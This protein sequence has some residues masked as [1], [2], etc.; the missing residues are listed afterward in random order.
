MAMKKNIH[1]IVVGAGL[2][3][4]ATAHG[5]VKNGISCSI[6]DRETAP[7]DRNWGV[8]LS[9]AHPL[10]RQ[11]LP[12]ALYSTLSR[13]QPDPSLD[14]KAAG[15]EC[16]LVRDGATG[17]TMVEPR[18]PGVRRL[19]IRKTKTAWREGLD[20]RYGKKLVGIDVVKDGV[21]ATFE[22]GTS[23]KGDVIVGADGGASYVRRWLLGE[24]A[25]QE[26]LPYT[27][28]NF[29]FSVK[30]DQARWLESV[31][32]PNV[33]V[34][35]HPKSMY[36][37]L[38]L[39]DKPDLER[40]ETWIFYLLVT[41]PTE[42]GDTD[43][44]I[45]AK[46]SK[47]RLQRLKGK[48]DGWADPY[49]SAVEWLPDDVTIKPDQLRIWHPKSWNSHGGRVTLSGDAAHSM[50][51]HRGQGGNLAIKDALEFVNAMKSVEAGKR[52]LEDAI[53]EYDAGVLK[54]GE[55]VEISKEQAIA[56]HNYATFRDSP[57]FKMGLKPNVK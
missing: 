47:R 28:M 29:P 38:F 44:D 30:T 11:L 56:F 36:I 23:E 21:V 46:G 45:T 27:F 13:C 35:T 39:L 41:W 43:D 12:D 5:L 32:N 24:A 37:G 15:K 20:I 9:W 31:M 49:K 40:P 18:Y 53:K 25:Q 34:A 55:E 1:V 52:T 7:R 16:V 3:G 33:D 17:E 19:N 48:M 50:T 22:D 57:I 6:Y 10:I 2:A 51:F 14:T 26:V 42:E 4:L 8:T 54:R